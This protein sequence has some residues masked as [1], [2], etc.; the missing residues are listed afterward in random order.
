MREFICYRLASWDPEDRK[1][2]THITE[3]IR[4]C[5]GPMLITLLENKSRE[6][7]CKILQFA[8]KVR[9][10]AGQKLINIMKHPNLRHLDKPKALF[11][12]T[13][14]WPD[15]DPE[16]MRELERYIETATFGEIMG[17]TQHKENTNRMTYETT[18]NKVC[19]W[20]LTEDC[21]HERIYHSSPE[22]S[23]LPRDELD[24]KTMSRCAVYRKK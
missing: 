10:K 15:V 7:I 4:M 11:A 3:M 1:S 8:G 20:C 14:G 22:N 2:E 21:L 12:I 24:R 19:Y 13:A 18:T 16:K 23:K 17:S 9:G 5:N 6:F